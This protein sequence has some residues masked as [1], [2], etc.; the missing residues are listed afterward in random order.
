MHGF[1][2]RGAGARVDVI[3]AADDALDVLPVV[4]H[5]VQQLSA[6]LAVE[7]EEGHAGFVPECLDRTIEGSSFD[8]QAASFIGVACLDAHA[9]G[10]GH[11]RD[12]DGQMVRGHEPEGP[13]QVRDRCGIV[14]FDR[15]RGTVQPDSLETSRA[16][17]EFSSSQSPAGDIQTRHEG[18]VQKISVPLPGCV[19]RDQAWSHSPGS[20]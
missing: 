6:V 19:I 20:V 11:W 9:A 4:A 8:M 17:V 14:V 2:Q 16:M 18:P 7:N 15:L 10:F 5:G 12:G 3:D 13:P 1:G